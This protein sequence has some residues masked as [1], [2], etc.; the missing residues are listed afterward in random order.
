M[1]GDILFLFVFGISGAGIV[2]LCCIGAKI[3]E[4]YYTD[5]MDYLPA[6]V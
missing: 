6:P 3:Y 4:Y 1:Q 2:L 5:R